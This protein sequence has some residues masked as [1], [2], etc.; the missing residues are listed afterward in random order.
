MQKFTRPLAIIWFSQTADL[1]F[2]SARSGTFTGDALHEQM[3]IVYITFMEGVSTLSAF[4]G[5]GVALRHRKV[6]GM[7]VCSRVVVLY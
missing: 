5:N 7:T 1:F 3:P 6:F 2:L 4:R